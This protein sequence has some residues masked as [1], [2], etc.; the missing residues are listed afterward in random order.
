MRARLVRAMMA[1]GA[2]FGA[3][4]HFSISVAPASRA[5]DRLSSSWRHAE[6]RRSRSSRGEIE[7]S[8]VV[9]GAGNSWTRIFEGTSPRT[10]S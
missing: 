6:S 3:R 8:R 4:W 7:R 1:R 2:A 9:R 5:S 10:A